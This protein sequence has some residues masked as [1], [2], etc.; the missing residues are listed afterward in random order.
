LPTAPNCVLMDVMSLKLYFLG[1]CPTA[2]HDRLLTCERGEAFIE[3]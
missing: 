3:G 1:V 2:I